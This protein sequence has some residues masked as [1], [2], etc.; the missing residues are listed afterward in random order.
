[1]FHIASR[2]RI[3]AFSFIFDSESED[4]YETVEFFVYS[5]M[6]ARLDV[7]GLMLIASHIMHLRVF[8]YMRIVEGG[9]KASLKD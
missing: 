7:L 6:F 2:A 8:I 9:R 4:T 1:M 3:H 5:C